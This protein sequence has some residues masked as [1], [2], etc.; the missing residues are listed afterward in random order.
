M[1]VLTC[2]DKRTENYHLNLI[3]LSLLFS[4][5]ARTLLF[6]LVSPLYECECC[7]VS[8]ACKRQLFINMFQPILNGKMTILV[9]YESSIWRHILLFLHRQKL[10]VAIVISMAAKEEERWSRIKSENVRGWMVGSYKHRLYRR[11]PFTSSW[12]WV[13]L[14]Y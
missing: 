11:P 10:C 2:R 3:S 9:E 8:A 1:K 12:L 4:F 14:T 6:W 7:S 5:M 13:T